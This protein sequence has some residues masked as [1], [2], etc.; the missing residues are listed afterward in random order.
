MFVKLK[1]IWVV[2]SRIIFILFLLIIGLVILFGTVTNLKRPRDVDYLSSN[3]I[4]SYIKSNMLD[5]NSESVDSWLPRSQANIQT[6]ESKISWIAKDGSLIRHNKEWWCPEPDLRRIKSYGRM[7]VNSKSYK[8]YLHPYW[9]PDKSYNLTDYI[10]FQHPVLLDFEK[11]SKAN[12]GPYGWGPKWKEDVNL[13]MLIHSDPDSK[14]LE[15]RQV[16]RETWMNE[17]KV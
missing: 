17:L 7:K 4:Q 5:F 8:G 11:C 3:T 6:N 9:T 10:D 1:R 16:N 12:M 2:Q 15:I 14:G 13:I